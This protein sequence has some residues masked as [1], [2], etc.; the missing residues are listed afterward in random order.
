MEGGVERILKAKAIGTIRRLIIEARA[1]ALHTG[2]KL[3]M[4]DI[5][6]LNKTLTDAGKF[7][8]TVEQAWS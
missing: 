1:L 5:A 3:T 8:D 6:S 2:N 7:A 4:E